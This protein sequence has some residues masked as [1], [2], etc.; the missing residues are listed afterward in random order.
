M[1]ITT[2]T[3]HL[4][5]K[6]TKSFINKKTEK[7]QLILNTIILNGDKEK[8]VNHIYG[9]AFLP[10]FIKLGDIVTVSGE[11][12]ADTYTNKN[13]EIVNKYDFS[14]PTVT[15]VYV[16][17]IN[18]GEKTYPDFKKESFNGSESFEITEEDLPF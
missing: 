1:A 18:S 3:A 17:S 8:G 13:G 16:D 5:E 6:N 11:T 15:K 9:T 7:E 14:F 4:T 12:K 2:V 10:P